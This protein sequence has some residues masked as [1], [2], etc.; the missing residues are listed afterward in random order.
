MAVAVLMLQALAVEGGAAGGGADEE[1][2]GAAVP[3]RPAEVP[4]PLE[5]E[6]GI[7]DIE[8][9]ERVVVDAVG[10]GRRQPG[11]ERAG[12]GDALLQHLAFDVLAVIHHQIGVG[13]VIQLPHRGIDAYLP[14][15]TLHA[16]GAGLVGDDGHHPLAYLLVFEQGREHP[17]EGHGGGE[18][19]LTAAL[20]LVLE[21]VE[22]RH[23]QGI[24]LVA[25]LR[26]RAA[27]G[28]A[29]PAHV[30]HLEAVLRRAV[31][32]HLL[33]PLVLHRDAE[34][35]AEPLQGVDIQFLHLMGGVLRL[36]RAAEGV[37]LHRLGQD[38]AGPAVGFHRLGVGGIDFVGV[39]AAAVE[40]HDVVIGEMLHHL[41]Q[42]RASAEEMLAGVGAA[43]AAVV[44]IV[45]VHRLVHALLQDAVL[46]H[47]EQGVPVA[48][49]DHF[50]HIP[51]GAAEDAFQF[52]DDLAVA[53]HR[54]VEPL[55]VAVDDEDQVLQ[56]L[57]A[58]F[59][60]G[61]QGFGLVHLAVAEEGPYLAVG[62]VH[63][64]AVVEVFHYV[65]LIDGLNG[66][67]THGDGGELPVIR[68]QPRVGVG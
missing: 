31:I 67:E 24:G 12:L 56:P 18:F 19:A 1:A 47:L 4:H 6:H 54:A 58:R 45:A 53:A 15:H 7:E 41:Q 25:A 14:E 13:G 22:I 26:H 38:D 57:A 23:F 63:Q 42:F 10:G 2:S 34:A 20:G 64:A 59:G 52:L 29:H 21:Q 60:D 61:A 50:D 32:R 49:P 40:G 35:V 39:V 37:A 8:G 51:A 48:A 66:A 27:E 43:A 44:L 68:H 36:A 33:Q 30:V 5:A 17:H 46:V 16:E 11:R 62:G 9:D 65:G 3:R 28:L 55:Q